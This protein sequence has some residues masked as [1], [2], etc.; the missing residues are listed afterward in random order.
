MRIVL[1]PLVLAAL[2]STQACRSAGERS[3]RADRAEAVLAAELQILDPRV[4]GDG[5]GRALL[6][7]L[8]NTTDTRVATS[9]CVDWFD[10]AGQ[11]V[12][13]SSTAWIP[14]VVEGHASTPVRVAPMP[15]EARSWRLRFSSS[16]K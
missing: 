10:A 12:P 3:A 9:L 14:L 15:V 5:P 2:A 7:A 11:R 1:I 6:F 8:R 16:D 13:L 4:A